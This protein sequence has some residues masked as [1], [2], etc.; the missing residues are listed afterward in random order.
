MHYLDDDLFGGIMKYCIFLFLLA[1]MT[2]EPLQ[3]QC[4]NWKDFFKDGDTI[5]QHDKDSSIFK[6]ASVSIAN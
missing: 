5:W 4:E 6:F 2:L 3:E 1:E